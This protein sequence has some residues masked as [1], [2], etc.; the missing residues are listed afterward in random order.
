MLETNRVTSLVRRSIQ[1]SS[2]R[3][4]L[5]PLPCQFSLEVETTPSPSLLQ[6]A[7]IPP[8]YHHHQEVDH[9]SLLS[10][11]FFP[12]VEF[13][14]FVLVGVYQVDQLWDQDCQPGIQVCAT[15]GVVV[16]VGLW[17]PDCLLGILLFIFALLL[18]CCHVGQKACSSH[19]QEDC[20]H[21]PC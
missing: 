13:P 17:D 11:H 6:K 16:I 18:C 1:V 9:L 15:C 14:P 20:H 5:R 7:K 8:S 12:K 19:S 4:R 21:R 3:S 10:V 2:S